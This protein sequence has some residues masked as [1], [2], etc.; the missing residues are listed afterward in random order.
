MARPTETAKDRMPIL[1]EDYE[2]IMTQINNAI[3][4]YDKEKIVKIFTS[5]SFFDDR[6]INPKAQ[7]DILKKFENAELVIVES[8]PEFITEKKMAEFLHIKNLMIA[9]GLE[10]ANNEV[11]EN[12]VNKGFRV[13]DYVKAAVILKKFKIPLKTYLLVKPLF[14]TEREA[15]EDA[16]RSAKFA[17]QY[18]EIISFNPINIQNYT[19]VNLLWKRGKYR[20]PWLWTILEILKETHRLGTVVSYPTAGGKRKGAHNCGE[21][22]LRVLKAIEN[23]SMTQNPE[24]LEVEDCECRKE[25]EELKEWAGKKINFLGNGLKNMLRSEH[26]A[27]NI[28]FPL[29]KLRQKKDSRLIDLIELW[30]NKTTSIKSIDNIKIEYAPLKA[31]DDNTSFDAYIEYTTK[32]K[33]KGAIGIEV[34]Y[35][36]SSYKYGNT[37]RA[38]MFNESGES[39]YLTPTKDCGFYVEGAN[40]RLREKKLK[41]PWRNH[42]L[43]I[44]LLSGE[45]KLY[46][47]FYSL[48]LYPSINTYQEDV[49]NKYRNQLQFQKRCRM[50]QRL[51]S[52]STQYRF[53]RRGGGY[54]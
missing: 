3:G 31:L 10:T 53:Q 32:S 17:S 11:L 18:S 35:T 24:Y 38:E 23:F 40:L 2:S 6:E 15:M 28:F 44:V 22:D 52:L 46:D 39:K 50:N 43:G 30:A 12:S 16:V 8:R 51:F 26:I 13:E 19:L 1:K 45:N 5:G 14:L 47:E 9:I 48:H 7:L 27:Y 36:E 37:E 42:L 33:K 34:K 41:Q 21:C 20:P 49:C 25:W 4:R 29:E 54:Y